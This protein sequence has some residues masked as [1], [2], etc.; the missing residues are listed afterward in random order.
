MPET[1]ATAEGQLLEI[2]AAERDFARAMAAPEPG[3]PEA[4]APPRREADPD[5]PYGRKVDGSPK[6]APGGRPAKPRVTDSK[7]VAGKAAAAPADYTQPL[8][9]FTSGLWMV[10]AAAPVPNDALRIRIRAQAAVL[11]DNQPELCQG[12][13]LAAQHN[14]TIRRGVEALTMGNAGWVLPA[15]MAL[16]PFAMQSARLWQADPGQLVQLAAA[17]EMQW[18]E[19]FAAMRQAMG[20]DED[21]DQDQAEEQRIA[22]DGVPV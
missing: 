7:P 20:L 6:K 15:V 22:R 10:L 4:P 21:Q 18:A 17:T 1:L 9:E 3:E 13:N 11:K 8:A 12:I 5:A 14:G 2:D 16:A 19:Q